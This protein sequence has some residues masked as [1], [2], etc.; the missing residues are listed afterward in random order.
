MLKLHIIYSNGLHNNVTIV[1]PLSWNLILVNLVTTIVN[2]SNMQATPSTQK[3][4]LKGNT[5]TSVHYCNIN[6]SN[7]AIQWPYSSQIP[8]PHRRSAQYYHAADYRGYSQW[9]EFSLLFISIQA[10]GFFPFNNT[11]HILTWLMTYKS[12]RTTGINEAG[13]TCSG[14][15][16]QTKPRL[17]ANGHT[18][19]LV[20]LQYNHQTNAWLRL[21]EHVYPTFESI[22]NVG[23]SHSSAKRYLMLCK[24]F[25]F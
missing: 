4:K 6:T 10:I 20:K 7:T 23:K 8:G 12:L 15:H 19:L 16:M 1:C 13:F 17:Y 14:S 22:V 11:C 25:V 5:G 3:G 9:L 18:S 2:L 24:A 21:P